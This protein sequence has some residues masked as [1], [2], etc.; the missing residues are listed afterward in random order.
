MK[1]SRFSRRSRVSPGQNTLIALAT[2]L[3]LSSSRIEDD[4]W[5]NR[6]I[7]EVDRL[8]ADADDEAL[9]GALDQL[10]NRDDRG[11]EPLADLVESRC[12]S[13]RNASGQD[14]V[15]IAAPILAW[16]R[17]TIPSGPI[18]GEALENLRVQLQ[19]H[20]LAAG[21]TLTLADF[22]FSPDHLPA[23]Y[24]ETSQW[25]DRLAQAAQRGLPLHVDAA[26]MP[27]AM[28]FLSDT[29]YLLG[30]VRAPHGSPLFRWQEDDGERNQTLKAWSAQGGQAL[31]PL[32]PACAHQLLIPLPFHAACRDAD[33]ASRPF[34]LQA[35]ADFLTST[36]NV[37]A[38]ELR[39]VVAPFFDQRLEEFRIG[40]TRS[41]SSQVIHGVV[42]PLLEAE[43]ESSEVAAQIEAALKA[44]G[45]GRVLQLEHRFPLEYCD[46]CGAPLYPN[47]EGEP[48]HAEMPEGEGLTPPRH[49]H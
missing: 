44:A 33:R 5:E 7:G 41:D 28:V 30:L 12:E 22:L 47:P 14:M 25:L 43:D 24:C 16:S 27:E 18:A 10:Y 8:L 39:A 29:R 15:L 46:D 48:M 36:L 21:A 1:R 20:G 40:F 26:Q 37:P 23:G 45:I 13:R 19:A 11:Y 31:A 38:S 34:A 9:T 32:L 17:F 4:F 49:L 2:A 35:S 42:W 3:G 6:L